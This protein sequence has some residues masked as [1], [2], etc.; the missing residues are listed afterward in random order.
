MFWI[1]QGIKRLSIGRLEIRELKIIY[2]ETESKTLKVWSQN[3]REFTEQ[4]HLNLPG[5]IKRGQR[6]YRLQ[7]L[8]QQPAW[9][10]SQ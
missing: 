1:S 7:A 2:K 10:V 8:S 3:F 5:D 9:S 4:H 6:Q